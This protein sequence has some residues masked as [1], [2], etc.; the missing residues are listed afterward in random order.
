MVFDSF[1]NVE[2]RNCLDL[3]SGGE[4]AYVADRV[5]EMQPSQDQTA[6]MPE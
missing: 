4:L 5:F 2:L 3:Y 6:H 1:E